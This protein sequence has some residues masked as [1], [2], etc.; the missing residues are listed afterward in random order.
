MAP[1][2]R[3]QA[4]ITVETLQVV[5]RDVKI[6]VQMNDD[7][8]VRYRVIGYDNRTL[9]DWQFNDDTIDAADV[10]VGQN[11]TALIEFEFRDGAREAAGDAVVGVVNV[12]YKPPG[13]SNSILLQRKVFVRDVLGDADTSDA[14]RWAAAVAEFAEILRRSRHSVGNRFDDVLAIARPL[15]TNETRREFVELAESA[16]AMMRR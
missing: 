1:R 6:Q 12:R 4:P 2:L 8:V 5:A 3:Y 13:E 14:F 7:L 15:A 9:E 16:A 10:G 11:V